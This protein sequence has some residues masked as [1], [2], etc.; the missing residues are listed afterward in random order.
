LEARK[1]F[2]EEKQMISDFVDRAK[3]ELDYSNVAASL[4]N[5]RQA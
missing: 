1:T 3:G 2:E 5:I 4:A